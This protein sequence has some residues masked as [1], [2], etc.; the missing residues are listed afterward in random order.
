M[1][2]IL[3]LCQRVVWDFVRLLLRNQNNA[4]NVVQI[5]RKG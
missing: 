4:Q 5:Q 1:V 2:N 3:V